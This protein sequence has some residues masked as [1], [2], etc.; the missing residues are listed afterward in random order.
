M[1]YRI[2][3]CGAYLDPGE[4]CEECR[5]KEKAAPELEPPK[6]AV[7]KNDSDSVSQKAS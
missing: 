2:C 3:E 5:A 1:Y 7:P 6:A 4:I